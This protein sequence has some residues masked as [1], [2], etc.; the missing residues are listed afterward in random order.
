MNWDSN[1]GKLAEEGKKG[2]NLGGTEKY[3]Q[4]RRVERTIWT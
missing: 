3:L 1:P 2:C 4:D